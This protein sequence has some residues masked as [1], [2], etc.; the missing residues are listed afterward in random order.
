MERC[1]GKRSV[2][3]YASILLI[4]VLRDDLSIFADA[5]ADGAGGGA[6]VM[7]LTG[8]AVVLIVGV[9][10]AIAPP[11]DG[12]FVECDANPKDIVESAQSFLV[13]V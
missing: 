9:G 10:R 7:V 12:A 8:V 3:T 1:S 13:G 5:L 2:C 4:A 11:V 6:S